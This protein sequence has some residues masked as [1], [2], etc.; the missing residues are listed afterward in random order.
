MKTLHYMDLG[1][2]VNSKTDLARVIFLIPDTS[3][4]YD[5]AICEVS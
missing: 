4:W 5:L 3:S 2:G 1:K